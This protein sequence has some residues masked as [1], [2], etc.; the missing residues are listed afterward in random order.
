M[1]FKL[2]QKKAR[3]LE[4][5]CPKEFGHSLCGRAWA[6]TKAPHPALG[7][8]LF[9]ADQRKGLLGCLLVGSLMGRRR[10]LFGCSRRYG[11]VSGR[12]LPR[13]RRRR[14][15]RGRFGICGNSNKWTIGLQRSLS[16][17][18][19]GVSACGSGRRGQFRGMKVGGC[20][21]LVMCRTCPWTRP[22]PL[23]VHVMCITNTSVGP[24]FT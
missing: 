3:I 14:L 21:L 1:N 6:A 15:L 7:P 18:W 9:R 19:T 11:L 17:T 8:P 20:A 4:V 10:A 5:P 12:R 2:G 16:Q 23:Q 22:Q 13:C 24:L